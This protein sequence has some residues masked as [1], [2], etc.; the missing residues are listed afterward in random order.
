M[1]QSPVAQTKAKGFIFYVNWN[2]I[3][4]YDL[5]YR[6]TAKQMKKKNIHV[7]CRAFVYV[8]TLFARLSADCVVCD[9]TNWEFPLT[10][11]IF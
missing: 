2:S 6:W 3:Y 10:I 1:Q 8:L 7:V 9:L 4:M 5:N 11:K